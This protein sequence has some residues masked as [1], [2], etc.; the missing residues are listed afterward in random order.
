MSDH[1]EQKERELVTPQVIDLMQALQDSLNKR[2]VYEIE[3]AEGET[4][5]HVAKSE[6]DARADHG[7][8]V[9]LGRGYGVGR[10][11]SIKRVPD[12]EVLSIGSDEGD[13]GVFPG[14][15]YEHERLI[16]KAADWAAHT[17]GCIGSSI[18]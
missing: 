2:H 1:G 13:L 17:S 14:C 11:V 16:A 3:D 8:C 9:K 6:A 12:E 10:C 18:F 7:E 5:L 15:R 4:C